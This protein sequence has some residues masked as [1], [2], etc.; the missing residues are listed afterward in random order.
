M[1]RPLQS[2]LESVL[3]NNNK[4]NEDDNNSNNDDNNDNDSMQRPQSNNS[5]HSDEQEEQEEQESSASNIY[6]EKVKEKAFYLAN[7]SLQLGNIEDAVHYAEEMTTYSETMLD[8][9][10]QKILLGAFNLYLVP[11]RTS[12]RQLCQY[13]TEEKVAKKMINEIKLQ[14][15]EKIKN[16]CEKVIKLISEFILKKKLTDKEEALFT[17]VKADH[18]RYMA[19]ITTGHELYINKQNAF[20]C[21]KEAYT[22]AEHF[23]DLDATKLN[24]ALNYS[25]FLY[26]I[27]NKRI[28]SFFYAK[29][30]LY[31]A[32][33]AL[34]D[35][36]EEELTNEDMRD[37]LMIIEVLNKNVEDWYKEEVGDIE[38]VTNDGG[39][40]VG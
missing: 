20:N 39:K 19:E 8:K 9:K 13:E 12:W 34:K 4:Q 21:Y 30:A 1:D 23:E 28:N 36:N 25:V 2:S 22:K 11:L 7:I 32:L 37:T 26:E 5:I 6:D 18:Y 3:S 15:E 40:N 14:K 31:K 35:C 10:Q 16:T 33:R 27:L 17:K 38:G 24:I 29:E